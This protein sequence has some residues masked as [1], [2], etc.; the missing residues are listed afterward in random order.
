[1]QINVRKGL[2]LKPGEHPVTTA[3]EEKTAATAGLLGRDFPGVKF[4]VR[5]EVGSR[6]RAGEAI[7]HDRQRPDIVFTAPADGI[8][9][10]VHHG[11]RRALRSIEITQEHA[12]E[13]GVEFNPP[14]LEKDA[15]R[16]FMQSSGLWTAFRKRPFGHVPDP[17]VDPA[18]LLVTAI[19]TEPFAPDPVHVVTA[20]TDWFELGLDVISAIYEGPV[21]LC[22]E[23]GAHVPCGASD[24]LQRAEF[25]GPHPAGLPGTH[26]HFLC[27]IGFNGGEVWHIGYQDVI[28][29]GCLWQTGNLWL[30]RTIALAG[31]A[32]IRPRV[33]TVPLGASTDELVRDELRPG[34]VRVVSG[35]ALSGHLAQG[36]EAYLGQRHRQIT[37][38]SEADQTHRGMRGDGAWDTGLGGSPGPLIPIPLLDQVAPPG[39]LAAPLMR[40]L[41]V[42]DVDRARDLGALELIE[43]DL[44]LVSYVCTSKNDYGRLLRE[45]LDQLHS[46]MT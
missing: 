34:P 27:P 14:A 42:G 46:E 31:P 5:V 6:V 4:H 22:Q 12:A 44:A 32:V 39:V 15:I 25:A 1:M 11:K 3:A 24:R 21:F 7:A 26:I 13:A 36:A 2:D 10:A 17:D 38:I 40:A 41:L 35:S 23:P 33:L 9:S 30:K 20:H 8:V 16:R 37:T 29:I 45:V 43:E 19:D 28:A 18:A